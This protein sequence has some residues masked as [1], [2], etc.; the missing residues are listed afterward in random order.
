MHIHIMCM[1][2]VGRAVKGGE[3]GHGG[4]VADQ[5]GGVG[6]TSTMGTMGRP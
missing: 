1:H 3:F 5:E 6:W 2:G 4:R